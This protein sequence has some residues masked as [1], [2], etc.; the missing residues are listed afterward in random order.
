MCTGLEAAL[1]YIAAGAAVAGA[2]ASA[3]NANQQS[4][5]AKAQRDSLLRAEAERKAAEDRAAQN[6]AAAVGET[7]KRQRDQSLLA[8]SPL[9]SRTS[10]G[11]SSA[12]TYGKPTLGS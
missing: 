4:K 8:A 2:G 6:A 3:A 9:A 5:A 10:G 7:R 1:P 12:L 11:V